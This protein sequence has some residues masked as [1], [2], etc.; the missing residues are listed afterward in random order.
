M[1]AFDKL[2]FD[3]VLQSIGKIQAKH[4]AALGFPFSSSQSYQMHSRNDLATHWP[5][6]LI[7]RLADL[8]D[9]F[10]IRIKQCQHRDQY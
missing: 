7:E 5:D 3:K 9:R 2:S 8:V 1:S 10:V 6:Y 4:V